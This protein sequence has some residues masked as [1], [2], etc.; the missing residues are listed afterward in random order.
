MAGEDE[1]WTGTEH[2]Q[3]RSAENLV[4]MGAGQETS[5]RPRTL[6]SLTFVSDC[7]EISVFLS[8]SPLFASLLIYSL[9]SA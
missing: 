4:G 2:P 3:T 7:P 6:P 5:Q 9:V 8:V 1:V